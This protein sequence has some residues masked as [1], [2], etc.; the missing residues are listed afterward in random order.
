MLTRLMSHDLKRRPCADVWPSAVC[1]T[2]PLVQGECRI[3][4]MINLNWNYKVRILYKT[5]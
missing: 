5:Q 2:Q 3:H 1:A 4:E